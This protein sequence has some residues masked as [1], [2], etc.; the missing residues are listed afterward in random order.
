MRQDQS[1][2]DYITSLYD[3]FQAKKDAS[4]ELAARLQ[5]KER[6]MCTIEERS[7]LL[8][9]FFERRKKL[10]AEERAAVV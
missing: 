3:E 6:E 8:A 9:E 10:L 4:E 1:S 5:M 7:K 2:V